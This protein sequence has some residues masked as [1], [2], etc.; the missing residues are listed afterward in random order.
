MD[1]PQRLI[2]DPQAP[3]ALRELLGNAQEPLFATDA[4]HRILNG[5]DSKVAASGRTSWAA[6]TVGGLIAA[7]AIAAGALWLLGDGGRKAPSAAQ[8]PAV[9]PVEPVP[10]KAGG[11]APEAKRQVQPPAAEAGPLQTPPAQAVLEEP[12]E[13]TPPNRVTKEAPSPAAEAK[14]LLDARRSL[15][16]DPARALELANKHRR[17]FK[18]GP[19][20]EEREY[21]AIQ[22][23]VALGRQREAQKRASKF[24]S[25]FPSS[26]HRKTVEKTANSVGESEP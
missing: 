17:E 4:T 5:V 22:A 23:L 16:D 9:E 3:D 19:L 10:G 8:P 7:G 6:K 1:E 14:L 24:V 20:A 21:L 18:R 12:A 25:S 26:P 15:R 11:A 2:E 13:P